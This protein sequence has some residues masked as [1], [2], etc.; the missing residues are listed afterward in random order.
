MKNATNSIILFESKKPNKNLN[1]SINEVR[2]K[3]GK[4]H[5]SIDE[6]MRD[7]KS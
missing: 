1:K 7:L 4:R 6:M 2:N 5:N 3:K